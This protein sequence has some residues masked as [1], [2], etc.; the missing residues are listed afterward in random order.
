MSTPRDPSPRRHH[1]HRRI[2]VALA[3]L[4]FAA[5][6][7]AITGTAAQAQPTDVWVPA[8]GLTVTAE[9]V[10]CGALGGTAGEGVITVTVDDPERTW[11]Y[12][13]R[14]A[15]L[16]IASP[17]SDNSGNAE[18][19]IGAGPGAYYVAVFHLPENG[20]IPVTTTGFTISPCAPGPPMS[21]STTCAIEGGSAVADAVISGLAPSSEYR[22][23]FVD[24][25]G[26]VIG[27]PVT[28]EAEASGTA[29][30]SSVPLADDA[31]YRAELAWLPPPVDLAEWPP[32]EF[33][34]AESL[35]V[36]NVDFPIG[37]CA[38]PATA[39]A[40]PPS[41]ARPA[42]PSLAESGGPD[43]SGW[44]VLVAACSALGVAALAFARRRRAGA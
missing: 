26:N 17:A 30:V 12:A 31:A 44:L 2:L 7:H 18:I 28:F 10:E 22:H 11:G 23:T 4:G 14:G 39:A 1:P 24:A 6:L 35:Q 42:G 25:A 27:E 41:T 13:V 5:G 34:P 43:A 37:T 3:A 40:P 20:V 36:S 33:V 8:E 21:I 16:D 32:T 19:P 29:L 38:A 9:A 15:T